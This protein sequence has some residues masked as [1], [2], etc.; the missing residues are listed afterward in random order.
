MIVNKSGICL[1]LFLQI[2]KK[3]LTKPP[4]KSTLLTICNFVHDILESQII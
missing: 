2:K 3:K 1:L 4:K